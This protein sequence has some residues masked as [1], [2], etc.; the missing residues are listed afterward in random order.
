MKPSV[1]S[2]PEAPKTPRTLSARR[3]FLLTTTI[4]SLGAAALV[5]APGLNLPGGYPAALAQNLS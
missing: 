4:A 5:I 2:A 3:F 1:I